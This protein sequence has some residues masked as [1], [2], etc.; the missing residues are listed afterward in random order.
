VGIAYLSSAS[1]GVQH[2]T[3]S[4]RANRAKGKKGQ[5]RSSILV[6]STMPASAH[7]FSIHSRGRLRIRTLHRS[8]Y[9][10]NPLAQQRTESRCLHVLDE[11]Y[12]PAYSVY[13]YLTN[14]SITSA[15]LQPL[16]L[17]QSAPPLRF[18]LAHHTFL[19]ECK[20]QSRAPA[21]LAT[22]G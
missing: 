2:G 21:P 18:Q 14:C 9:G 4:R 10:R 7:P 16:S 22:R 11:E 19:F 13:N 5:P 1:D 17:R 3:T 12:V 6:A 20:D 15:L 8:L